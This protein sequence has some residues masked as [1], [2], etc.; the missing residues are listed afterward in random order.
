MGGSRS[1]FLHPQCVLDQRAV[2]VTRLHLRKMITERG[3]EPPATLIVELVR[4]PNLPDE[5]RRGIHPESD[6]RPAESKT[7]DSPAGAA[8]DDILTYDASRCRI[9]KRRSPRQ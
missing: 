7:F 1:T 8:L 9:G 4:V 2:L 6:G 3:V 5:E